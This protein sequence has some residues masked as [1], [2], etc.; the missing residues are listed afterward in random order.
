M[1]P[2]TF[3]PAE[4]WRP[5]AVARLARTLYGG[6]SPRRIKGFASVAERKLSR[7]DAAQTLGFLKPPPGNH[8]EALK[9]DRKGQQSIRINDRWRICFVWT[10]LGPIEVEIV[11]YH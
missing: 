1:V 3:S 4:A 7:P 8:L 9:R 5:A 2:G 10:E 6:K 11:D